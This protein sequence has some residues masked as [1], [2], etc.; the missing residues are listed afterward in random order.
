MN[1]VESSWGY[2]QELLKSE[3]EK[4]RKTALSIKSFVEEVYPDNLEKQKNLLAAVFY[5]TMHYEKHIPVYAVYLVFSEFG[6][7]DAF[8]RFTGLRL[9]RWG[10]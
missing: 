4:K 9:V 5:L 8:E 6:V 10:E 2:F 7:L 3:D 1:F